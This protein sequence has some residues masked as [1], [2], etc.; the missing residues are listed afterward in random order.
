MESLIKL[1]GYQLTLATGIRIAYTSGSQFVKLR[2][3]GGCFWAAKY[4]RGVIPRYADVV[5]VAGDDASVKIQYAVSINP[6]P[7]H[8]LCIDVSE[9]WP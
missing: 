7:Y 3:W 1:M 2:R 5:S 8:I 9:C 4:A 6:A